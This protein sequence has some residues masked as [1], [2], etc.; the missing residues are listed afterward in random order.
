MRTFGLPRAN[1]IKVLHHF[2][3]VWKAL[4][5]FGWTEAEWTPYWKS[6]LAVK[7]ETVKVSVYRKGGEAL[8][9]AAN[10]DAKNAAKAE[11]ALPDGMTEARDALAGK[12]L[13]VANGKASV[14]IAPFR[15][16]LIRA[17]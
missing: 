1:D 9:V 6:P 13:A 10:L 8:I 2:P 17:R 15:H 12:T 14:E 4:E 16:V 3:A 5:D 11:I 7:P